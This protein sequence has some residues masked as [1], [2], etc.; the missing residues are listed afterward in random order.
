AVEAVL[1]RLSPEQRVAVTTGA[2]IW[3]SRAVPEAGLPEITLSDGPHGLR[4]QRTGGDHLGAIAGEPA[5]CFPPA[6]GIG[7]SWDPELIERVGQALGDEAQAADVQVLLG[8]GVNLKRDP[9]CGRNFEYYSEDPLL[10]GVLGAALVRGIQSRGVGASVKHF[11]ANNQESDRMRVSAD[12]DERTLRELYLPAFR[13]IIEEARPW[14]VMCSYNRVNGRFAAEDPWLRDVLR[15]EWGYDGVLVSDWGAVRDRVAS[16]EAGLDLEMPGTE[17]PNTAPVTAAVAAGTLAEH[18]VDDSARRVIRLALRGQTNARPETRIDH[19]AHHAL[20]REAAARSIVLLRNEPAPALAPP[21]AVTPAEEPLLPLGP[22]S[23]RIAV[24][25]EFARS[26]RFQGSGSSRVVPTRLDTAAAEIDRLAAAAGL[27]TPEFAPGVALPGTPAADAE[28]TALLR[29]AEALAAAADTV[30]LF[31]GLPDEA[32]SEGFDRS[33]LEL[34]ADQLALLDR[35][36]AVAPR[37][38]VVLSNGGV[39]RVADWHRRVP[40]L[41][42]AWLLGQAGGGGTADVLF[43][44]VSPSGRLTETIPERLED[45]PS[46][47]FFPGEEG[48]VRY[49]E[50]LYVGYRMSE[51]VGREVSYPFGHGLSYASFDYEAVTAEL[52]GEEVRLS[53]RLRNRSERDAREV[54]QVYAGLPG[55]VV[56]R[57]ATE[58]RAFASVLVPAGEAVTVALGFPVRDL[59]TYRVS[60]AAWC[61]EGGAYQLR[62]GGSVREARWSG[63]VEVPGDPSPVPLDA[64]ST[65]GE[66]LRHPVAGALVQQALAQAAA[67]EQGAALADPQVMRMAE[68]MTLGQLVSFG[69]ASPEQLQALLSIVGSPRP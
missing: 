25:G 56:S 8:P 43:G 16:L 30:L 17:Q 4:R 2:S 47:P 21:G 24:I 20:A 14:T 13:R 1:A 33:D 44:V 39:V 5:T 11:A 7:A 50:G 36:L 51:T 57:P 60:G 37:T 61:V 45:V 28:P 23:G 52:E 40:A 63:A 31:L 12:I 65:L 9:R 35:V 32:E 62:V 10:S 55:A 41:L 68:Q 19:D 29:E 48:H 46:F 58:L 3:E 53:V 42:E 22:G 67:G 34:P 6:V 69:A 59:A 49:G 18:R 15:D 66:W 38:A 54:V 27:P 26:P 64:Q